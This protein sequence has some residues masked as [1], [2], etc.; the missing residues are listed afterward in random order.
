[1]RAG[2]MLDDAAG[3]HRLGLGRI[4]LVG[5]GPERD[6][7]RALDY[8]HVPILIVK[9]RTAHNPRCESNADDVD[10]GLVRIARDHDLTLVA[11]LELDVLGLDDDKSLRVGLDGLIG[12]EWH[13]EKQRSK[14]AG[15]SDCA[16]TGH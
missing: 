3:F 8:G 11:L 10:A 2:G 6:P 12:R 16:R 13:R 14:S 1:M 9:V 7:P 15:E 4:K 5:L